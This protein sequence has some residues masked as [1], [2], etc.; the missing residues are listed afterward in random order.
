MINQEKSLVK[1]ILPHVG[2][3]VCFLIITFAY[4]SPLLEGKTLPQSDVQQY[5]GMAQELREYYIKEGAS[6]AWT[7]SMFSGMPSYQIGV[8]GSNPNLLD[9]LERP[10]KTIGAS[11]AG[12]VFTG[13]LMAYILFVVMGFGVIPAML[14]AVAY[15][16]SSYNI[17]IIEAG[18]VTKAWT[19]AYMPMVV[20]S[21]MALFRRKFLISGLLMA[22]GLCMMI[23]SNHLQVTYYAGLLCAL[24]YIGFLIKSILNKEYKGLLKASGILVIAV[25]LAVLPNLSTIYGNYEMGHE[26]I[27]GKSELSQPTESE[28]QSSGLDKDY[29]FAWSYGKGETLSLLIPNIQGGASG[30]LLGPESNFYK[31]INSLARASGQ[32]LPSEG[33]QSPT[34]WGDQPFTSGPVYFGAVICFLFLLGMI[35]IKSKVKWIL[36]A[37]TVLFIFLSWGRNFE[38]FN[39]FFFYHFPFYNKF[40]AVSMGLVIPALTMIIVA[41]WG[42]VEFFSGNIE[43]K[44]L[45]KALYWSGGV[46]LVLCLFFWITPDFFFNFTSVNDAQW[47]SQYPDSAYLALLSDRKDLLASDALRSFIFIALAFA[48]LWFSFKM[49]SDRGKIAFS[50]TIVLAVLVL[51]DLW[52]VDKRY[53]NDKMFQNKSAYTSQ[54]FV[55]SNAD[56][57]ILQDKSP[58]YRVLNLNDPFRESRTSYFHKSIGGYHAAKLKR[59]QELIDY[60]LQGEITS[61]IGSFESQNIDTI[62]SGFKKLPSLNMLNAKYIV[63]H[64]EQPPLI[65]PYAYGNAWFVSDYYLAENAD[66]EIEALNTLDP[67]KTAVVDK[68]FENELSGFK[69]VPDSAASIEMTMYKPDKVSYKSKTNSEQ[70][71]VFS[72]IYYAKG[73]EAYIDGKFVPHFRV[74][75]TLRGLRVPQGEHEIEFKFIPH[76][77]NMTRT[78]ST[79]SSVVLILVLLGALV[80]AFRRKENA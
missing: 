76:T 36:L 37:A 45:Q 56:K 62:M 52:G 51:V 16:L 9:Y 21:M 38:S 44:K 69:I 3:I 54:K 24:L 49:K 80:L 63:F 4:F 74:D 68:R 15:S 75:W 46:M 17:I 28:K 1:K 31:Q 73:W 2:A 60:R 39:D 14:G 50:C 40:R 65:N 78:I 13:M 59:Y 10:L 11:S 43:Q 48:V 35:I 32:Q 20:A 72:E 8:W 42:V 67:R 12:P 55:Q 18:H 34:Y 79:A 53:L 33:I 6:S 70:L 41:V 64:P 19:L 5:E 30:G 29:A 71:A 58:S 66:K 26:S 25:I 61:I 27:R 23:K 47:K 57:M 77:Y 22:L 7:G